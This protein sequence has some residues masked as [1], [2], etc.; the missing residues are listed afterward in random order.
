MENVKNIL[1]T[2]AQLLAAD[3]NSF[4]KIILASEG[5]QLPTEIKEKEKILR[6]I[7]EILKTNDTSW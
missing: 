3:V 4:R 7:E 5:G 1:K 2:T 6:A